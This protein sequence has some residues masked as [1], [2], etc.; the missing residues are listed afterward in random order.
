MLEESLL[1]F[2]CFY[3]FGFTFI[4]QFYRKYIKWFKK[5]I[6]YQ[7]DIRYKECKSNDLKNYNLKIFL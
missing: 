2:L 7:T 4:F 3:T 5:K 6:A 1:P